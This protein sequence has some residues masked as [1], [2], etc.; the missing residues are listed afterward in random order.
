M[1]TKKP[2]YAE[3]TDVPVE[4][5]RNEI[6]KILI[7]RD[8]DQRIF[9]E[10]EQGARVMFRLHGR[11]Y[12]FDIVYPSRSDR[13]I[14]CDSRGYALTKDRVAARY[15]KEIQRRWRVLL[16]SLK[17]RFEIIDS[18]AATVDQEFMAYTMLPDGSTVGEHIEPSIEYA[19][20]TGQIPE[21]LPRFKALPG[22][23][24]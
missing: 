6:E 17:A 16:I 8:A 9:G 2:R 18:E 10:D 3:G 7:S 15:Q 5:S 1:S 13:S 4:K 23:N 22:R 24:L 12:K 14:A 20:Q 21:L 19:Y 11:M